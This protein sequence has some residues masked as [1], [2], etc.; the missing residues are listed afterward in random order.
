MLKHRIIPCLL[1]SNG[2]LVKTL[3]FKGKRA[4]AFGCYGWSGESVKILQEKLADAGFAVTTSFVKSNW[5]PGQLDYEA[6]S[7]M[8]TELSR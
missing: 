6:V 7:K 2:G 5:N 3:K 4:A 1:L 8:V